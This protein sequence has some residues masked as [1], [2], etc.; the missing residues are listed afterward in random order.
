MPAAF[1]IEVSCNFSILLHN[2]LLRR[3]AEHDGINTLRQ[4]AEVYS[5][6]LDAGFEVKRSYPSAVDVKDLKQCVLLQCLKLQGYETL[7][8]VGI[9]CK[10]TCIHLLQRRRT[11][12]SEYCRKSSIARNGYHSRVLRIAVIPTGEYITLVRC[13]GHDFLIATLSRAYGNA[14]EGCI[15]KF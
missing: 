12:C 7:R 5:Q 9:Q 11:A 13:R 4:I 3:I 8:R 10:L 14:A 2:Q 1:F 15:I 6:S